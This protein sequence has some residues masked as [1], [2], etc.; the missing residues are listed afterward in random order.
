MNTTTI[1]AT[2]KP[3]PVCS[4]GLCDGW[5]ALTID[6]ETIACSCEAGKQLE[7]EELAAPCKT[8]AADILA[9][10]DEDEE[11][12]NM[13]PHEKARRLGSHLEANVK[14]FTDSE[15]HIRVDRTGEP[16]CEDGLC[17]ECES[18]I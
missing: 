8:I 2:I 6:G 13:A 7:A 10:L 16:C 15:G 5:G 12:E 9:S 17:S 11:W 4:R 18:V 14:L 1:Q 3:E